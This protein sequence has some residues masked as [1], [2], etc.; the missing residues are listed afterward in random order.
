M[1]KS[2]SNRLQ[3]LGP[4]AKSFEFFVA[5]CHCRVVSPVLRAHNEWKTL[6]GQQQPSATGS[7]RYVG[8]GNMERGL[9]CWNVFNY[10]LVHVSRLRVKVFQCNMLGYLAP[11]ACVPACWYEASSARGHATGMCHL[12]R[13]HCC[14]CRA[15]AGACRSRS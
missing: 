6:S 10:V 15:T 4:A 11:V 13:P 1:R 12:S 3:L 2:C 9:R 14:V 7:S 8:A 5:V